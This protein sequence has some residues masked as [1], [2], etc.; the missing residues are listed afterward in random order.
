MK[1]SADREAE[2][3]V[4]ENGHPEPEDF[5]LTT[6]SLISHHYTYQEQS[7][8][9]FFAMVIDPVAAFSCGKTSQVLPFMVRIH[10]RRVE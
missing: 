2:W 7:L 10:M 1:C 5:I 3:M 4:F 9:T 6:I 8:S